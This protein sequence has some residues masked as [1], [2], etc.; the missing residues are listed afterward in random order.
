[1]ARRTPG[2]APP[3]LGAARGKDD[4][5]AGGWGNPA[6]DCLTQQT[7]VEPELVQQAEAALQ[8]AGSEGSEGLDPP[9]S[10][11]SH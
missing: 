8:K 2:S 7:Q 11:P 6:T 9:S 1:M 10:R 5:L 3:V 4:R